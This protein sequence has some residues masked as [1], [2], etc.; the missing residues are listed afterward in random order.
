MPGWT[1]LSTKKLS[2]ISNLTRPG[3]TR[4]C[5]LLS[6][7]LSPGIFQIISP[8]P[9]S[10]CCHTLY[11]PNSKVLGSSQEKKNKTPHLIKAASLI[12]HPLGMGRNC[13]APTQ[14]KSLCGLFI[15]R[16]KPAPAS[17]REV[18]YNS[19]SPPGPSQAAPP[20]FQQEWLSQRGFAKC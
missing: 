8:L 16:T 17:P 5:F 1:T 10:L 2:L 7:P 3:A 9:T 20:R 19:L 15:L 14:H 4:G 13:V 11:G 18:I 6:C 12:S